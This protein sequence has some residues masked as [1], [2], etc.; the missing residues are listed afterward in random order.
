MSTSKPRI[1]I[2][3]THRQHEL[4]RAISE[5]SGQSM[6]SFVSELLETAEPVF[7]RMAATFQRLKQQQDQQREQIKA[8]LE[9][10]QASLEPLAAGV[11]AQLDIFLGGIEQ[12][13]G[14]VPDAAPAAPGQARK[15]A[16]SPPTNRGVTPPP[17]K[18]SKPKPR[19]A[20]SKVG[21]RSRKGA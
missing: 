19:A 21:T 16:K 2:T 15:R 8:N 4:L 12:A 6:S 10:A 3:L 17:R 11:L 5:S 18:S 9:A 20:S 14:H 13:S 1:T 7:E